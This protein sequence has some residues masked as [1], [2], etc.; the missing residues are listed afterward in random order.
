MRF[1]F[2]ATASAIRGNQVLAMTQS[3]FKDARLLIP[4]DEVYLRSLGYALIAFAR[5]EW[6]ILYRG[7]SIKTGFVGRCLP[8]T[9]GDI[10]KRFITLCKQLSASDARRTAY[11]LA[12]QRFQ[13]LAVTRNLLLHAKPCT[14]PDSSQVLSDHRLEGLYWT[15]DKVN[16]AADEFANL[17]LQVESLLL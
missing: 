5:L 4:V 13:E 9:S 16:E 17:S 15:I 10:A 1:S 3:R 6:S 2:S 11:L 14:A 12:G 7:E 8:D